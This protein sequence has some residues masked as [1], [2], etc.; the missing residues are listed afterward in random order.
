MG[1]RLRQELRALVALAEQ[2]ASDE[3]RRV[4]LIAALGGESKPVASAEPIREL[5]AIGAP[6][7]EAHGLTSFELPCV[8]PSQTAFRI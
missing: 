7:F 2:M 4:E 8:A 5:L 1:L 3:A 6:D